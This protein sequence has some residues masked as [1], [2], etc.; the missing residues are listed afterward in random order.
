VPTVRKAPQEAAAH[1]DCRAC[2]ARSVIPARRATTV[3]KA[4]RETKAQ[5]A[6]LDRR[7]SRDCRVLLAH[8][9]KM[10]RKDCR[11][12]PGARVR[13]VLKARRDQKA[14]ALA[15]CGYTTP[16]LRG[17]RMLPPAR[18]GSTHSCLLVL[19]LVHRCGSMQRIKMRWTR[20]RG[21]TSGAT[22]A[23]TC[24]CATKPT[25]PSSPSS[26]SAATRATFIRSQAYLKFRLRTV[27]AQQRF[28]T[29]RGYESRFRSKVR[30]GTPDRRVRKVRLERKALKVRRA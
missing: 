12:P 9:A 27:L 23:D 25:L 8:K 16:P 24:I 5:R 20:R 15:P 28:R 18:S 11:A 17:R 2:R 3:R 1:K 21:S 14:S 10:A 30:R 6:T 13:R 29:R 19:A 22:K 4:L 26:S 7:A